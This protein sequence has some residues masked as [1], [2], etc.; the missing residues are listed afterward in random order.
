[1]IRKI[2]HMEGN[3][4]ENRGKILRFQMTKLTAFCQ[5]D[6]I[7]LFLL[8]HSVS[9]VSQPRAFLLTCVMNMS[10]FLNSTLET[11]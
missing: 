9:T 8:S 6:K 7:F 5:N 4:F 2:Y 10:D 11:Q 3:I 1:M